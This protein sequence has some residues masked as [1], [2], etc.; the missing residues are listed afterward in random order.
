MA[1]VQ[2]TCT[3]CIPVDKSVIGAYTALISANAFA[4]AQEDDREKSEGQGDYSDPT[5]YPNTRR[6]KEAVRQ[7]NEETRQENEATRQRQEGTKDGSVPGDG[8][9]WG[10]FKKAQEDRAE[11]YAEEEGSKA[12]SVAGDGSRWGDY[13]T[14]EAARDTAREAAEGTSGSEA[15]DGTRWGVYKTA[16]AARN[17]S[18]S[19]QEGTSSAIAGDSNRWGQYKTAEAAR[20]TA[21]ENAEGTSSSTAGDGTRWGAYKTAEAARDTAYAGEEGSAAGSTAGDGTRW[22]E[23]M[24]N[25]SDRN[26]AMA[27]L[28]GSYVCSTAASTAA[29]TVDATG[30]VLGGGGAFKVKFTYAN[31]AASPTLNVNST[32]AKAIVFNGA[33]AGASNS[34]GAGEVVEFYYDGTNWVGRTT[35]PATKEQLN[36]LGQDV[37]LLNIN[38]NGSI[39]KK[40]YYL[41]ADGDEIA[42][43]NYGISVYIPIVPNTTYVWFMEGSYAEQ[44]KLCVYNAFKVKT[45]YYSRGGD[46]GASFTT[47]AND[48]YVR[49]SFGL[50]VAGNYLKQGNT[51]IWEPEEGLE[52]RFA[53][54]TA[55]ANGQSYY[56][57]TANVPLESGYYTLATAIAAIPSAIRK[58]GLRI[59]YKY[60]SSG[61]S[62]YWFNGDNTNDATWN[63]T[64]NWYREKSSVLCLTENSVNFDLVNKKMQ[65]PL[66]GTTP[67][68][69]IGDSF[70]EVPRGTEVDITSSYSDYSI[71]YDAKTNSFSTE[72]LGGGLYNE[73]YYFAHI[74]GNMVFAHPVVL[75]Y[76]VNGYAPT[77]N[78]DS[79]CAVAYIANVEA[80]IFD[81]DAGTLVFPGFP[82]STKVYANGRAAAFTNT[83]G[84]TV[85][86]AGTNDEGVIVFDFAD[87]TIKTYII[88]QA[89]TAPATS[90]LLGWYNSVRK[91]AYLAGRYTI[92]GQHNYWD[93]ADLPTYISDGISAHIAKVCQGV[94]DADLVFDFITD[95][96]SNDIY[97]G[98]RI[99]YIEAINAGM[100]VGKFVV[101]GGDFVSGLP[102]ATDDIDHMSQMYAA[103]KKGI[104]GKDLFMCQGNHDGTWQKWNSTSHQCKAKD[105]VTD[106]AWTNMF[107]KNIP[108]AVYDSANPLGGYLYKDYEDRKVRVIILNTCDIC[109][110]DN[111]GY[112]KYNAMYENAIRQQQ[113]DWLVNYALDFSSKGAD[114]NNWGIIVF[115]HFGVDVDNDWFP[116]GASL[117]EDVLQ[118]FKSGTAINQ[119]SDWGDPDF[120]LVVNHDFSTQGAMNYI[121]YIHGHTHTDRVL[122]NNGVPHI[123][124]ASAN[125][126]YDSETPP[127]GGTCPARAEGTL[128]YFCWDTMQYN[129]EE[130]KII[131]YRFG[132][133]S[134]RYINMGVNSVS[135]GSS[136]TLTTRLSGTITWGA[137]SLN[138]ANIASVSNGV[139]TGLAEGNATIFA[140]DENGVK[141]F[142]GIV[143]I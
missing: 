106:K 18:Y 97:V 102:T 92:R 129:K 62:C 16:E 98:S 94:E 101:N 90:V 116:R 33:E 67:I 5:S 34:W 110:Y 87:N 25:E 13:K 123:A 122:F 79:K 6:S 89:Y 35:T 119:S 99:C 118:A 23:F 38:V 104:E 51:V 128:S 44:V 120:Q 69:I 57:V 63:N 26:N 64:A 48:K 143:V 32:G 11:D 15:G 113:L 4:E 36:Q 84:L 109:V 93:Y 66:Y 29:K 107:L 82:D 22:G 81:F 40:G 139:V 59:V 17:T 80:A 133:G 141:E 72:S 50:G 73:Q 86:L 43:E 88:H 49:L 103:H 138:N 132:A 95:V 68:I 74:I 111:D 45:N 7:S 70:V 3:G 115:T 78:S 58:V 61:W 46:V 125:G 100:K 96:Q 85:Q 60:N 126:V 2:H 14:A 20:N 28:V 1:K 30:Y 91:I 65:F 27:P 9:R 10:D 112:L 54:T 71:I 140:E 41:D 131:A 134:D 135:V 76:T 42:N 12:G 130:S 117:V 114:K 108:G 31:T 83:S 52:E 21:R 53:N 75:N 137:Y 24:S 121:A 142:F 47:G 55:I 127:V 8:S 56:N 77:L 105:V 19:G 39:G 37:E 124:T 136:I